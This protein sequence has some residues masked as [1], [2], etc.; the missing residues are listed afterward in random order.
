LASGN[1]LSNDL[2]AGLDPCAAM[3]SSLVLA[4]GASVEIAFLLGEASDAREAR[5]AIELY[6]KADLD[7]VFA[8]VGVYWEALLGAVRVTTPDRAM[9]IMLNGWLL[10]QTIACR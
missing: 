7:A 5:N 9:D 2:G 6:R 4:P 3:R 10:Y 1:A 8:K